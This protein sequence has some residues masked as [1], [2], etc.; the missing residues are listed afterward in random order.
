MMAQPQQQVMMA[1][2]QQQVMMV[3]P[4]VQ[5]AVRPPLMATPTADVCPPVS[6]NTIDQLQQELERTKTL[7]NSL[8][9]QPNSGK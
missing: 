4:Q 3:Q 6:Q 7:I 1:Q 8:K 9:G 5:Q 2:P